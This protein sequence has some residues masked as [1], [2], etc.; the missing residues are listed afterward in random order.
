[1]KKTFRYRAYLT[2]DQEPKAEEWLRLC[3]E[4]YNAALQER[5]DAWRIAGASVNFFA[6][7]AQ[8]PEI[9]KTRP[10]FAGVCAQ[11]LQ[12]V[13]RRIDEAFGHFFRRVKSGEKP[14]YPRFKGRDRYRS[15]T[16]PQAAKVGAGGFK[17]VGKDRIFFP[18]FGEVKVV[19]H[20][21]LQGTPKTCTL[22]R[23]PDGKW[24]VAIACDNVPQEV[25][26]P[27]PVGSEVGIDPGLK[28]YATLSYEDGSWEFVEN[29]RWLREAEARIGVAQS[30]LARKKPGSHR[31]RKAKTLLAALC[32]QVARRRD[33]FQWKLVRRVVRENEFIAVE[34]P[35]LQ[36][37]VESSSRGLSKS[38]VDAALGALLSK[39]SFKAESASREHEKVAASGT[40]ST[41]SACGRYEKKEL[42]EDHDCP[43][44][45]KLPRDVNASREILGRGRRLR[46][47]RHKT[48][49]SSREVQSVF[50][51]PVAVKASGSLAL[52]GKLAPEVDSVRSA[53]DP[54][55][56]PGM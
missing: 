16:W 13:L 46:Q 29:P 50:G 19:L 4:L 53:L 42:G 37:L 2:E 43:C 44:G 3:R 7:S 11:T 30:A 41:C 34:D 35:D 23:E 56:G 33:D 1:M 24:Y 17:I 21:P 40:S 9:K 25:F 10:E 31:R 20:R 8:L 28:Y 26:T 18:V 14:G 27:A 55:V 49:Q 32:A 45:C 47:Q 6:Q 12:N 48:L 5:S 38:F 54:V 36:G 51:S 15:L 52:L 22:K 39:L